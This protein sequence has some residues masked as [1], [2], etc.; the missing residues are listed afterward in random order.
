MTSE[1]DAVN[2]VEEL[3][4]LYH[5]MHDR[6]LSTPSSR[7]LVLST[8]ML[9]VAIYAVVIGVASIGSTKIKIYLMRF[10]L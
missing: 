9:G 7:G 3:F 5:A 10:R 2:K 1:K 8:K 6:W 4:A